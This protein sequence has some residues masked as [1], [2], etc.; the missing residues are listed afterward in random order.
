MHGHEQVG[1]T[2]IALVQ[3]GGDHQDQFLAEVAQP[4]LTAL[5]AASG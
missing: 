4:L 3:I 1:F 2:D 5:R